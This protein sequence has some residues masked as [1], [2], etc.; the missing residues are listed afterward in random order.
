VSVDTLQFSHWTVRTE[1]FDG[2]LD[3]LLYLVRRDGIDL[4]RV[5]MSSIADAYLGYLDRMRELHLGI[6][7]DYL[8]MAATLVHLKSISL[9]PRPPTSTSAEEDDEDPRESLVRRLIDYQRFKEA[10]Q[11]LEERPQLGRDTFV[12]EPLDLGDRPRPVS[13]GISAFA[14]LD[15]YHD[16]LRRP[17]TPEVVH[18]VGGEGYDIGTMVRRVLDILGGPG[19]KA[20][21]GAMLRN[22]VSLPERVLTFLAV[23]EMARLSWVD[24]EQREHL[25]PVVVTCRVSP[26]IELSALVGRVEGES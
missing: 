1:V 10:S 5:S 11:E 26:D 12:R 13:A 15:L 24:L 25:G 6:A 23:L 14:L 2:P 18:T 3:L 20:E 19:R 22:L 17:K 4:K 21:L 9:L 7:G 8:V 16:I